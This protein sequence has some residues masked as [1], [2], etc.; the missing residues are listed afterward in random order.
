MA[1]AKKDAG[2][3]QQPEQADAPIDAKAP[4]GSIASAIADAAKASSSPVVHG[5]LAGIE[6]ALVDLKARAASVEEHLRDEFAHIIERIKA[7]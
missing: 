3:Q 5:A 2:V 6:Q 7:L 4:Q 1:T